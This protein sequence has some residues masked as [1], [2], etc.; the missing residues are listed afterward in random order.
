MPVG[1]ITP[2]EA[3]KRIRGPSVAGSPSMMSSTST[4]NDSIVVPRTTE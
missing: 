3:S 2:P 4:S 1:A